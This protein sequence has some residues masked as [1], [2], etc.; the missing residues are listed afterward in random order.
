VPLVTRIVAVID[1]LPVDVQVAP[2]MP[3][4][5]LDDELVELEL[6][7][8]LLVLELLVLDVELLELDDPPAPY[9]QYRGLPT[10]IDGNR[11]AEHVI[12]P[13][14]VAYTKLPDFP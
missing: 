10:L 5:L 1:V 4:P 13:V 7:L 11:E 12:G 2:P 9:E 3:P 8:E 6:V 14:R